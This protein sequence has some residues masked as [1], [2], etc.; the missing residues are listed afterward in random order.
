MADLGLKH[1]K[2]ELCCVHTE[3]DLHVNFGVKV[4]IL[5]LEKNCAAMPKMHSC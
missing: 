5:K 1:C 2:T 4:Q 3:G